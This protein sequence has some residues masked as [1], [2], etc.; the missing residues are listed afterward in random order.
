MQTLDEDFIEDLFMTTNHH[1]I[2]FFTNKGRVYRLKAYE[3]PESSRTARG[4]AIINLLQL[5][6]QEKITAVISLKEYK[7]NRYLFMATK[8]GMV[9]KTKI[10]EYENIRKN[11]L[12]AI[13]L[14][15][16]D[17]LIEVKVTDK[18]SE[19]FLVTK[20]GM[21]IRFKETDV[22]HTGRSSMGV[23]GMNLADRDE[24]IGMQLQSQGDS[25]LFVSENG[26]GK[27]TFLNEFSVQKRGGKGLKC[28]KITE[29]TGD[30][31]GVKAVENEHEIMLI[32]TEGIIIQLRVQ[33]I[34][35]L[36]RITSGVRMMNLDEGIKV[37]QIAKVRERISNGEQEY[38]NVEDALEQ[39]GETEGES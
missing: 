26:M 2:M 35:I 21:C 37:A 1:Y 7:D 8:K 15:E 12:Q 38:D 29:K 25:L 5:L 22:R 34:S 32:T 24:V 30:V 16:E 3:I 10:R 4:T 23:I 28:Y 13:S 17:E 39:I 9:K 20:Q 11:G 14:K 18:D 6:P 36:G 31:I 33:D 27:R 19:I